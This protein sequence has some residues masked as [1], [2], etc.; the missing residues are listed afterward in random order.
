MAE[1]LADY[2]VSRMLARV[3]A[4]YHRQDA[5]DWLVRQGSGVIAG[6]TLAITTGDDVHIGCVGIELRHGQWHLGYWLN[7]YYWRRGYA[8]EAVAAVIE[9]FFRRMPDTAGSF[10]RLCRQC[11]LAEA[12]EEARLRDHRL[13]PDLLL[14]A[15]QHGVA[16]SKPCFSPARCSREGRLNK[17]K[18]A[19]AASARRLL[20]SPISNQTGKWSEPIGLRIDPGISIAARG[21]N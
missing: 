16:I 7:R 14:R 9:R 4:P 21:R 11:R 1:S 2:Q 12:A 3:P 6:W 19:A 15:Q 10:R 20:H 5:L 18:D 17:T 8:S 13:Q